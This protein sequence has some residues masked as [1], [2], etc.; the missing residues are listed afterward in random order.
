MRNQEQAGSRAI[1]VVFGMV[2]RKKHAN[3]SDPALS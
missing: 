1:P 3:D 2:L